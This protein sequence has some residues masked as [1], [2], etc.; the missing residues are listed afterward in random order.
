MNIFYLDHDPARAALLAYSS[1]VIKMNLETMQMLSTNVQILYPSFTSDAL[2]KACYSNHPCTIWARSSSANFKWLVDYN[3]ALFLEYTCRYGKI[4]ASQ[5][6]F[7]LLQDAFTE[8]QHILDKQGLTDFTEPALAMPDEFKYT[9]PIYSYVAYYEYKKH[10]EVF[11]ES[12]HSLAVALDMKT[13]AN[14]NPVRKIALRF[15]HDR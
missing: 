2:M 1:H 3:R 6:R 4:H 13:Y 8:C 14:G 9:C 11:R 7:D 12:M 5:S 15:T 10:V